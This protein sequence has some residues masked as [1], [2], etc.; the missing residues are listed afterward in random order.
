MAD[1][2]KV[3][4]NRHPPLAPHQFPSQHAALGQIWSAL[5]FSRNGDWFDMWSRFPAR[6]CAPGFLSLDST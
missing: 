2:R 3:G 4:A 5:H 1:L 6:P